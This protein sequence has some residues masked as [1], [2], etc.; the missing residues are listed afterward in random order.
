MP[1]LRE[2]GK[3]KFF[4][5][6]IGDGNDFIAAGNRERA[7]GAEIILDIHDDQSRTHTHNLVRYVI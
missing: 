3:W 7:T 2:N 6:D 4:K 5:Q 1:I